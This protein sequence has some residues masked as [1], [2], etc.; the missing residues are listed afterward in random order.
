MNSLSVYRKLQRAFFK[1]SQPFL[2]FFYKVYTSRKSY[3]TYK[4]I[5]VIIP[6]GVFHPRFTFSTKCFVD[7]ILSIDLRNKRVLEL[8]CGSGLLSLH[9]AKGG[10]IVTASDIN[11]QAVEGVKESAEINHCSVKPV[12]SDLFEKINPNDFDIIFINPP[13]YPKEPAN[14]SEK[15]WFCGEE[16]DY[17]QKLFEQLR[18]YDNQTYMILSED[19]NLRKISELAQGCNLQMEMIS[20]KRMFGELNWI[21]N[22]KKS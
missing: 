8:G 9:A 21:F 12:L 2:S 13:Y 18:K 20:E 15:A 10:A 6:P 1:K 14:I 5:R 22:I 17:F 3:Y 16:Y 4:G 11:E 7:F 19:C